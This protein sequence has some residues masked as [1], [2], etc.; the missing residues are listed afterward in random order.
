MGKG[1]VMHGQG[2]RHA[3]VRLPSCMGRGAVMHG[4]GCHEGDIPNSSSK[5]ALA[6]GQDDAGHVSSNHSGAQLA[7]FSHQVGQ[8]LVHQ[9]GHALP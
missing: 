1:A 6:S 4:R 7:H 3:W 5:V 8:Y 2:C 9:A